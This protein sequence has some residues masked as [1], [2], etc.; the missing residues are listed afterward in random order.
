MGGH[1][2]TGVLSGRCGGRPMGVGVGVLVAMQSGRQVDSHPA[3][4]RGQYSRGG[5]APFAL[6][7][8]R[9]LPSGANN[10]FR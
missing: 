9:H 10:L 6:K 3:L 8:R 7:A 2:G 1:R 5:Q 4:G